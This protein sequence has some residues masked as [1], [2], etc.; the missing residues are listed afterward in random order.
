MA[1]DVISLARVDSKRV[2][3]HT[4]LTFYRTE[5]I[6]EITVMGVA[7]RIHLDVDPDTGTIVNSRKTHCS[8]SEELL[9]DKGYETRNTNGSVN[10]VNSYVRFKDGTGIERAYKIIEVYPDDT[11]GMISCM[12]GNLGQK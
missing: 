7:S 6:D 12:L 1:V 9:T 2:W 10:L 11:L 3:Q 4:S 5:G 8:V